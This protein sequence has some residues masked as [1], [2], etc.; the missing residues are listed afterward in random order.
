[1]RLTHWLR[2]RFG[3]LLPLSMAVLA[4][5]LTGVGL[6]QL[7]DYRR[8]QL[9]QA[10]RAQVQRDLELVRI[11][12]EREV[13]GPLLGSRAMATQIEEHGDISHEDF[14]RQ[15]KVMTEGEPAILD[16]LVSRGLVISMVYPENKENKTVMGRDYKLTP[17]RLPA[18]EMAMR[19]RKPVLDGPFMLLQGFNG[20]ALREAVFITDKKSGKDRFFGIVSMILDIPRIFANAGLQDGKQTMRVAVLSAG[21]PPLG[22]KLIY[23]DPSVFNHNPISLEM[24]LPYAN[25]RIVGEPKGGWIASES[26]F[27]PPRIAS[28]TLFLFVVLSS[29]GVAIFIY[30]RE[31]ARLAL[32]ASQQHVAREAARFQALLEQASDGIHI[33]DAQGRVIEASNSFCRMLGYTRKELMGLHPSDWDIGQSTSEEE[34]SI[35]LEFEHPGTIRFETQH[36]RKD[37]TV[38]DVEVSSCRIGASDHPL[39]FN[40][41]RDI[42][43]R[44]NAEKQINQ[45]A[46]FDQLT[47]LPNRTLLLDRIKTAMAAGLRSSKQGALLFIDLDDFKTLNDTLGHSM[48]DLLLK[49]VAERLTQ[50]VR[51]GDTVARLGGDEFLVMTPSIGATVGMAAIETEALAERVVAV[52]NEPYMLES[53]TYRCTPSVGVTIFGGMNASP[54]DLMK[55]ADLAMY[56]AKAAGRNT[57]RFFDPGMEIA[58][59]ARADMEADLRSAI[60]RQQFV[61]H[62]Q[63][64]VDGAGR[65]TGAECL[66]RWQ[67]P[68]RGLVSPGEFIPLA[69]ETGLILPLGHWVLETACRQ[70]A[71][72]SSLPGMG[73]FTLAVNVSARQFR[74]P[75]FVD[76]VLAVI[77][78]AGADPN[79]LKLELTESLL[80]ENVEETIDKMA[81]LKSQGVSFSLDDFGTGYSSLA[82][83]KRL[84]LD[85]L[86][87]DQSFV[88]D[89]MIDPND[90]VLAKTVVALGQSLG[91]GVIAEGVEVVE[92]R[93]FLLRS[94]CN[95]FQGFLFSRPLPL[96]QFEAF[97]HQL[98]KGIEAGLP[99]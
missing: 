47:G 22:Q 81:S 1:M 32:S 48:G 76:E 15:A 99:G 60:Q 17:D 33:L 98:S 2:R 74:H 67:H 65:P 95:Y 44:K 58:V 45:L 86:K 89:A 18:I 10:E 36:R 64:Q 19:T 71:A 49:Q 21:A 53:I 75:E 42:T 27:S 73:E 69:E 24:A 16:F 88:R 87:I 90:A 56:K 5:A 30:Q 85:Q 66:V 4:T 51:T 39:L 54:G 28:Y 68:E 97:L 62:Y 31:E 13:V 83:L 20:L 72:W 94:G 50:C 80:V 14:M 37:G 12:L 3:L 93:D 70:L 59:R 91:L 61:L 34:A 57:I 7:D 92:Q 11:R 96:D 35:R 29:F 63:V 78:A 79:L 8:E 25:W 23:G 9:R 43:E 77:A 82:Y 40:S 38:F 55:Q 6:I 84:P 41:S 26:P 46:F 52:L